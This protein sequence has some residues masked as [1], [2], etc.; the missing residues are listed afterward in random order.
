[1]SDTHNWFPDGLPDEVLAAPTALDALA[2]LERPTLVRVPGRGEQQGRAV[3]TLLHGDESTGAEAI[4]TILRQ[5]ITY[6]FDL[7]VVFGNIPAALADDGFEHRF[8]DD[9]EDFNRIWGIGEPTTRQRLA[10]DAILG[11]LQQA[12]LESCVDIHNNSG[13]NPFYAIVMDE[14]PETLH[15]ATRFTTTLL[16]WDL[17]A[18]TLMEAMKDHCAAIA[19]ECGLPGL[20][21]SRAFAID[22]LRRYLGALPL[23]TERIRVDFDLL[24]G[25]RKV[26]VRPEVRFRFGGELGD[27]VDFVVAEGA[28][29]ANFVEV[30]AGHVVGH[31]HPGGALPLTVTASDGT[32]VTRQH[33]AV[34]DGRV[35]LLHRATPVMMTRTIAAAR[36]DCLFYLSEGTPSF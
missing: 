30:A 14:K 16:H 6:P 8:L 2:L 20:P 28:D 35:V 31:V 24:R 3:A 29:R 17:S 23:P 1:M 26:T 25:L 12:D 4:L 34:E 13:D 33:V 10:A 18:F 19:V 11:R 27:D 22:G 5:R 36:K 7:Y 32:D 9:Q 21:E 15:L